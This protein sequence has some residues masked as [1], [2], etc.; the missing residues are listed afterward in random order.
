MYKIKPTTR[1][2]TRRVVR[3]GRACGARAF[4]STFAVRHLLR[5]FPQDFARKTHL[6]PRDTPHHHTTSSSPRC[7]V[8]RRRL[9]GFLSPADGFTSHGGNLQ[10]TRESAQHNRACTTASLPLL[11]AGVRSVRAG[12][13]GSLVR[14][15]RTRSE[16]SRFVPRARANP[17]ELKFAL[18]KKTRLSLQFSI[19]LRWRGVPH[20]THSTHTHIPTCPLQGDPLLTLSRG[21]CVFFPLV[22]VRPRI[23]Q[24]YNW[25][26]GVVVPHPLRMRKAPGSNPGVSISA[27]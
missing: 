12:G 13:D 24:V 21:K 18:W 4:G 15:T 8:T 22:P 27:A 9:T 19:C 25:A 16:N 10:I 2:Q 20:T 14:R 23:G 1:P 17:V 6:G 11:L 7:G 26:H 5:F 3:V